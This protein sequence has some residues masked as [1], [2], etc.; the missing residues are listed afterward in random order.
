MPPNRE[1]DAAQD[2]AQQALLA[3]QK[4]QEN[5]AINLY[6]RAAELEA[7]ALAAIPRNKRRTWN[8]LAVSH[9]SLLYKARQF[10]EAEL[11]LH[12]YLARRDL[13]GFARHQLRELLD[14]VLDERALPAG[15]K[16][17][18]EE[19]LFTLRG[20][21]IGRGTAPLDL[22]LQKAAQVKNVVTRTAE[23]QGGFPFRQAGLPP[24]EVNDFLQ[25]RAG[26]PIAGSYKFALK[27][28]EPRQLE[29]LAKPR[30]QAQ[31]VSNR[32]FSFARLACS[33]AASAREQLRELVPNDEYRRAMLRLLRNVIPAEQGLSEVELSRA[34]QNPGSLGSVADT[35]LLPKLARRIVSEK[36]RVESPQEADES[37][38]V[39]LRGTLRALHLDQNWLEITL[40]DGEQRHCQT[41]AS[42]LDDV[43]GPMV[44]R[45][46]RVRVEEQHGGRRANYQLIDIDLD[47]DSD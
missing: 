24:R 33:E 3:L 20:E 47:E 34:R 44:N 42:V 27:L 45:R 21:D 23:L 31:D 22:V 40:V 2:L 13:L 46:V 4:S 26:Q 37:R 17:S 5:D 19:I 10:D 25:S 28:V 12:G 15:Y 36:L 41:P 11:A 7:K 16:Y 30:L 38:V 35:V 18:G 32:L 1:H 39:E 8:I 14:V 43:V 29:L 9:A 6:S